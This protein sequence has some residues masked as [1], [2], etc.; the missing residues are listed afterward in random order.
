MTAYFNESL[1]A[2]YHTLDQSVFQ[3]RLMKYYDEPNLDQDPGWYALRNV[4]FAIGCK[5]LTFKHHTWMEAQTQAQGYFDN[6]LS[7]EADLLHGTPGLVAVQALLLM[8]CSS[9]A[10]S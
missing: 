4:V 6:A 10:V 8:V 5:I 9:L 7:V 3:A 2:T 1:E